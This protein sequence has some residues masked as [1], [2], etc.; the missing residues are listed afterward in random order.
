MNLNE[1]LMAELVYNKTFDMF[2]LDIE[3]DHSL[4]D[5]NEKNIKGIISKSF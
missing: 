2:D 4:E 5:D 3:M 1:N